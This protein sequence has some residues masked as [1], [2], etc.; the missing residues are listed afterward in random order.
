MIGGRGWRTLPASHPATNTPFSQEA[1]RISSRGTN[2]HTIRMTASVGTREPCSVRGKNRSRTRWLARSVAKSLGSGRSCNAQSATSA[3]RLPT[4]HTIPARAVP[5]RVRALV[6]AIPHGEP[7]QQDAVEHAE[8]QPHHGS[9]KRPEKE[10][11]HG[12]YEGE[13]QGP[14]RCAV[15]PA[16]GGAEE[17]AVEA[18]P[19]E[20]AP[21]QP[22]R[23][24]VPCRHAEPSQDATRTNFLERRYGEVR[25]IRLHD[26]RE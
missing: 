14:S 5:A 15:E 11:D 18:R 16:E 24:R 23:D 10:T 13:G 1:H 7:G 19:P 22:R 21:D 12:A 25:R 9:R 17:H 2:T 8:R 3:R 26:V 20:G 4:A 6:T